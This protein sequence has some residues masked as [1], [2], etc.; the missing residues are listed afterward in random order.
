MCVCLQ[1]RVHFTGWG[2][3]HDEWYYV[4]SP[5]LKPMHEPGSADKKKDPNAPSRPKNAYMEF[6][7]PRRQQIAKKTPGISFDEIGKQIGEEWRAMSDADKEKYRKKAQKAS[8]KY[9][10]EKAEYGNRR[11]PS[12]LVS[13]RPHLMC[14]TGS[15]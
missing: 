13:C 10:K 7:V 6:A 11:L 8:A 4:K 14:I 5:K 1:V 2:A 12:T 9:H 15:R 3:E